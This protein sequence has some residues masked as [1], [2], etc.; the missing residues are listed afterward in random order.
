MNQRGFTLIELMIVVAIVGVLATL[1][2]P[3]Y[4][5]YLVRA[6]VAEGLS[7]ASS[8]QI[9][10]VEN[11]SNGSD[12]SQGFTQP[13]A[14]STVSAVSIDA[15]TGMVRINYSPVA[16]NLVLTLTPKSD[17]AALVAGKVPSNAITWTCAVDKASNNRYVP[18]TCRI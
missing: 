3:A 17:G 16:Q 2:I 8:A 4:Q 1:A 18:A 7:L 9:A 14:T 15:S 13:T 11:A 5:D 10:V 12:F 6:R